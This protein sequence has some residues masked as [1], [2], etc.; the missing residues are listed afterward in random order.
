MSP[1]T[2][3]VDHPHPAS[4][5]HPGTGPVRSGARWRPRV[6]QI[7]L[8]ALGLLVLGGA[9]FVTLDHG[10]TAGKVRASLAKLKQEV[11]G[12][13]GAHPDA[14]QGDEANKTARPWDG[15]VKVTAEEREA[16]GFRILP[17]SPQT[18]PIRL[19]LPGKTDY[20]QN[21]LTKIRPKFDSIVVEKVYVSVGQTVHKG[22]PLY[23][24]TSGQLG[25][26]MT[27]CLN[28]YVQWDHD[29]KYKTAREPLQKEGR[30]TQKDWVDTVNDE[31]KSRSDYLN[32]RV[33]LG[34]YQVPNEVVDKMLEGLSDDREKALRADDNIKDMSH[35]TVLSKCDGVV[36]EYDSNNRVV[37]PGNRYTDD[38]ILFTISPM[39][40]LWVWADV[41]ESDQDKVHLGQKCTIL[42]PY[43]SEEFEGKIESIAN[44]VD[45]ETRTVRVRASIPNPGKNLKGGMLVRATLQIKPLPTDTVIP[46]NALV[47]INND[48][49]AFIEEEATGS[50]ADLFERRKLTI[51]Q[52]DHDIVIVKNGLKP[53]DRVV[54]NG[55]LIL[56]QMYED[57][58]TVDSGTPRP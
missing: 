27:D 45:A 42:F 43:T 7:A 6:K 46:R 52:E 38:D 11:V 18:Q 25:T 1:T 33:L 35:M 55:S 17:V 39:Q 37:V 54:S 21:T 22:D 41:F 12:G 40:Q 28:K 50:K 44:G 2:I 14:G 8:A 36:V 4:P 24:L 9:A 34:I 32:A 20:D 49:Y 47:V 29:L 15:L 57:Q 3:P 10:P 13:T 5:A 56:A 48:Y 26:A 19:E 30:I 31:K 23:D 53:G 51:E 58:S 16:I